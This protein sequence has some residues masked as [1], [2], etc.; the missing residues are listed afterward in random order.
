MI[1]ST[2][3]YKAVNGNMPIDDT[4]RVRSKCSSTNYSGGKNS[5]LH[6]Y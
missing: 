5:E 2:V 3:A 4:Y 1:V 6:D